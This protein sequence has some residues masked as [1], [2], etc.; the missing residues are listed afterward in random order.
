M[1][2]CIATNSHNSSCVTRERALRCAYPRNMADDLSSLLCLAKFFITVAY[3]SLFRYTFEFFCILETLPL[4]R[5]HGI[6]FHYEHDPRRT[7]VI[8]ENDEF[9]GKICE[10]SQWHFIRN[11]RWAGKYLI[12]T[13]C[14]IRFRNM[15]LNN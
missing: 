15:P 5:L 6:A 14:S 4:W 13:F 1:K 8:S 9:L 11:V 2:N 12:L 7:V 3:H 10:A